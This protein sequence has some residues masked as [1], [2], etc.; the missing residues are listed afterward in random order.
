MFI[1][2]MGTPLTLV[3]PSDLLGSPVTL[4]CMVT[5]RPFT[6]VALRSLEKPTDNCVTLNLGEDLRT[7]DQ[8]MS[9]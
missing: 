4:G 3:Y 5:I 6:Q 1:R 2:P 7:L 9:L 8:W